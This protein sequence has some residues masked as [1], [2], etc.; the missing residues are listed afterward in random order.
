M[1]HASRNRLYVVVVGLGLVLLASSSLAAPPPT[2]TF[3]LDDPGPTGANLAGVYTSPY[4]GQVNY[5]TSA[6]MPVICDDFA[7]ESFV[8]EKWTAYVTT[9]PQVLS[10]TYNTPDTYLKFGDTNIVT[11]SDVGSV[12]GSWSLTQAQAYEVAAILAVD[13]LNSSA[14]MQEDYSY[15]MWGLFESSAAFGQLNGYTSDQTNAENYLNTAI[16]DVKNGTVNGMSLSSYLSNYNVTIYSYDTGALCGPSLVPCT[17]A[18]GYSTPPQE[19]ITVTTPEASTPVLL[20]VDFFGFIA[21]V[22]FLRK[23]MARSS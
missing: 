3:Y 4:L 8:P 22:G 15:A 19:F 23:R 16:A 10:G 7:D 1:S 17:S 13:V 14:T 9:L 21:L 20:A 12:T 6:I 18:N 5:P 2:T 11:G